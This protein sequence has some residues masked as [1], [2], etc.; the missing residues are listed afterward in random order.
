MQCPKCHEVTDGR[1]R[2]CKYCGAPLQSAASDV[3]PPVPKRATPAPRR[4]A[5]AAPARHVPD[6]PPPLR[7]RGCGFGSVLL[8]LIVILGGGAAWFFTQQFRLERAAYERIRHSNSVS[9]IEQYLATRM[10]MPDEHR[11]AAEARIARLQ[12]DSVDFVNATTIEACERYLTMHS[13]GAHVQEVQTRLN[14]LRR[15]RPAPSV[16]T[17]TLRRTPSQ[18][19][20]ADDSPAADAGESSSSDASTSSASSSKRYHVVAGSYNNYDTA[21]MRAAE[22]RGKGFSASVMEAVTDEGRV[23][24]VILGS[25]SD[26]GQAQRTVELVRKQC[27]GAWVFQK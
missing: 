20:T 13:D 24:R 25:Y 3:P 14:R 23:Y 8:A 15:T 21:T 17:D 12:S 19:T 1:A 4:V 27:P 5:T 18:Q 6:T 10:Y 2:F 22:M 16:N 26:A 11:R 7:K 9:E